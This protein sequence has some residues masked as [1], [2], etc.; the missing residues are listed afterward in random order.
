MTNGSQTTRVVRWILALCIAAA[1]ITLPA[2]GGGD[3]DHKD[4]SHKDHSHKDHDQKD[5][6][7]DDKDDEHHHD[8]PHGGAMV[9]LGDHFGYVELKIY[10]DD[11][12]KKIVAYILSSHADKPVRIAQPELELTVLA[13]KAGKPAKEFTLK[14]KA[15]VDENAGNKVGDSSQFEAPLDALQGLGEKSSF[16]VVIKS[17]TIAGKVFTDVKIN[18]PKGNAAH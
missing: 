7:H 16:D 4:H 1:I 13:A 5:D 14:L 3:K 18:Y 10:E 11:A 17:L 12:V 9:E 15:A 8:A 6:K 2:C